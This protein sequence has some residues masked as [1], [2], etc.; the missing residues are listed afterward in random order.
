MKKIKFEYNEKGELIVIDV[1]TGEIIDNV[2]T[3]NIEQSKP[4]PE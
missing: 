2:S 1:E 4:R 3:N